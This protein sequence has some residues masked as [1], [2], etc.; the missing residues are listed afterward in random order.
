MGFWARHRYLVYLAGLLV[1]A[2]G[3]RLFRLDNQS[4]WW[5][6]GISLHL[7]TST[8]G[9][10]IRDRLNNIHPPLY[11]FI[12]KGWLSLV[13][14]SPFTGR[15]LSVLASLAQVA[16]VFAAVRYWSREMVDRRRALPWLAAALLLIAPV[17]VIYG[18]EIRVY[19]FL[20][21]AYLAMLL[22]AERLLSSRTLTT[23]PLILL[24]AAEWT[25][26]HLHYIALF[27]VAYISLW[28]VV[29]LARRRDTVSL[30]RWIVCQLFVALASLPWLVAVLGNWAAVQIEA[31]AGTFLAE[32]VPPVYLFAQVW[33]FH[34]TGLAGALA[35]RFVQIAA[36]VTAL[37]VV[38]LAA[39]KITAN[40]G[41]QFVL[42]RL[43]AHWI[44][45]LVSGLVVWSV[46]SFSH[47]RYIIMFVVMFIPVA[48]FLMVPA[49]R[50]GSRVTA[51][52]LAACIVTLSLWGLQRYFFDPDA[53][54]PDM[55]GVARYLEST[56][57]PGAL[58]IVPDTDWSLVF[59][60]RGDT[61]V[62][63]PGFDATSPGTESALSKAMECPDEAPCA[64]VDR[65]FV[66]DYPRGTRDWQS[67]VPFEL[68]RRGY[69]LKE[70]DFD[71]VHVR[72][73]QMTD[74]ANT[75][76]VCE[77]SEPDGPAVSFGSLHLESA[78]IEADAAADTAVTVA[79]CWRTLTQPA[80][81][82]TASLVLLDPVTGER[83]GQVD[84][85]LVNHSGAP[86]D[87]WLAGEGVVTYHV[88]PLAPGTPP[89]EMNLGLGVY[90]TGDDGSH[91]IEA[92]DELGNP[93]GELITLG[94]ISLGRPVGLTSAMY[95]VQPPPQ[96]DTPMVVVPGLELT[97]VRFSRGPFRPGQTIRVGLTWRA[98]A[99]SMPDI[100]PMLRLEQGGA[101]LAENADLPVNGRYPTDLWGAGEL[102]LEYRDV[103]A[104]VGTEGTAQ[105][106]VVVDGQRIGLGEVTI[107]GSELLFVRP[108]VS[109]ATDVQFGEHL[110]LIGYDSPPAVINSS[111]PLSITLYWEALSDAIDSEYA[112]FTH[113]LAED[114][115][116]IAQHDSV[117]AN[118]QRPTDEWLAGEFIVDPH[119]LNWREPD[120]TG[121]A[122]LAVGLYD[123]VS[124]ERLATADG[125]DRFVLPETFVVE[126]E[127]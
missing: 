5:D 121:I 84:T 43:L 49:Q 17:F 50:R 86:S 67:R 3:L 8:M 61:P 65:V 30:R 24:A 90:A 14:V 39:A 57:E 38:G 98:T 60:Y 66:V 116:L 20:P 41:R 46:R 25:G 64:V 111:M 62:I 78:W 94:E 69:R 125:S 44:V 26:L 16:V 10:I 33:A 36:A 77:A 52:A 108:D 124:G 123:P 55:R 59:E 110:A 37:L 99:E 80:D 70:T 107:E 29:V 56:A 115:R 40:K 21:L 117:P 15:Y 6:E 72:E 9:E 63:M 53:A 42:P 102:V 106:S 31:N 105:L 1:L 81:A 97:D 47:P 127:N 51:L 12:L 112:V 13:G 18:Q 48:V 76:P 120:Y 54:K 126:A 114:G 122:R 58:I 23:R 103:R 93:V 11:F 82:Y 74:T 27:A 4:I 2:F 113:L 35:D 28:G 45:P 73:Y 7:A 32:P 89:V 79:L 71:G 87:H 85:A 95:D 118:G 100:R 109:T 34:L 88:L 101:I 83:V 75:A 119:E 92:T 68:E 104:P 22:P 91:P 19:A 96:R